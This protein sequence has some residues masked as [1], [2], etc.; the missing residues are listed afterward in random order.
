MRIEALWPLW[1]LLT[2]PVTWWLAWRHR[3][4]HARRRL[5]TAC[6][7]RSLALGLVVLALMRPAVLHPVDDRAVG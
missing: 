6:L 2:L 7:L 5:W 1:L 3:S 4:V